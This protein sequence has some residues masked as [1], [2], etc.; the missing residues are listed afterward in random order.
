MPNLP[1]RERADAKIGGVCAALARAWSV[2]PIIIRVAFVLLG[3]LTNGF[4]VAAYAALWALLPDRRG[5]VTPLHQMFPSTRSWPWPTL[6]TVVV[7]VAATVGGIVSGSGPGAVFV[8]ALAW[9]ILRFGFAGRRRPTEVVAP[10]PP[11]PPATPFQ[12]A[13]A[14]WQQ[15]LDNLEAGRPADWVPELESAPVASVEE[16]VAAPQQTPA[17][18]RRGAR[19]WLGVL[20]GLGVVWAGLASAS[21]LGVVIAPLAWAS[22]TLAVLALALVWSARP[23]RAAYG[24][25][26]FLLPLAVLMAVGTVPLLMPTA[27]PEPRFATDEVPVP[28]AGT[29]EHLPIGEHVIDLTSPPTADETLRYRLDLGDVVVRVPSE[30][31]VVVNARVDLGDVTL[32]NGVRDGFDVTHS[33]SRTD[34]PEAPTRTIDIAV[35]FG[36]AEVTT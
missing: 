8:L 23:A 9:V 28:V 12:R 22:A 36:E 7:L 11:P 20:V 15:R 17:A 18:R 29:V 33:W 4:I 24:R 21:A 19:T 5:G 13:A 10:A 31:N 32:P 14:A 27:V 25:P 1:V 30:G 34:D 3:F 26:P 16:G 35:G 6:V 2:D